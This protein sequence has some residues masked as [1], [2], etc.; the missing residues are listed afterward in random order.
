LALAIRYSAAQFFEVAK[1]NDETV[2]EA[3]AAELL[4]ISVET[5]QRWRRQSGGPPCVKGTTASGGRYQY[6]LAGLR[7]FV[8]SN[9]VEPN[10]RQEAPSESA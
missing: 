7:E 3:G 2:S 8:Q 10:P 5:L 9:V 4:N 6:S 1:M